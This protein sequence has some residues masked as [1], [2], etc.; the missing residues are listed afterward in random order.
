MSKY[1]RLVLMCF[2]ALSCVGCDQATKALA[3]Q[4]LVP[5]TPIVLLNGIVE[6]VYSE[7]LGAFL[8]LGA[9]LPVSARFVFG[10]LFSTL[11]L[12]F[13]IVFAFQASQITM[14]QLIS[15]SFLIG[16]GI[17]NLIDRISNAG[18]VTDFIVLSLGPLHTGIFNV[19][20]VAITFGALASMLLYILQPTTFAKET[21]EN[22]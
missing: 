2:I 11:L 19:A 14:P 22:L 15:L 20:D 6:L 4:T 5:H 9:R 10:V 21:D 1:R 17:G 18:A 8:G 13:T 7:N 16:G 12:I 3:R